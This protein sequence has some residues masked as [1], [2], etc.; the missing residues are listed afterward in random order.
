VLYLL[1]VNH[2]SNFPWYYIL[3]FT[4]FIAGRCEKIEDTLGFLKGSSS[5]NS[6]HLAQNVITK[7]LLYQSN[8]PY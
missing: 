4:Y 8:A 5:Y 3:Y 7:R 2:Y 6:S 1:G